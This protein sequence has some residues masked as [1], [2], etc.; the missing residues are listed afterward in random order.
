[1]I[2]LIHI[3][4]ILQDTHYNTSWHISCIFS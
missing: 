4:T 1:M 3:V 2:I